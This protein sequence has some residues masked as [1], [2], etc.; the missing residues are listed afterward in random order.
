MTMY[1][2]K[3]A[4]SLF[5]TWLRSC[6]DEYKRIPTSHKPNFLFAQYNCIVEAS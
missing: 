3:K 2:G 5:D 6:F 4:D 1:Q